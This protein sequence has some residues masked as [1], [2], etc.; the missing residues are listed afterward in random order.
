MNEQ[1]S[2]SEQKPAK[3]GPGKNIRQMRMVSCQAA[4][5]ADPLSQHTAID[6][7]YC[8]KANHPPG[9]PPDRKSVV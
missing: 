7:K 6:Q 3:M 1:A 9:S 5:E 4:D 8:A 2:H